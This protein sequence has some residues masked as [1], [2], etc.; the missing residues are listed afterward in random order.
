[1]ENNREVRLLGRENN[2]E[3]PQSSLGRRR[4]VNT[5]QLIGW[6]REYQ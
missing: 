3:D 5:G 4:L 1:M 2:K 6:V